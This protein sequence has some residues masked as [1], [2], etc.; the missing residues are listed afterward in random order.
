MKGTGTSKA[1][2]SSP[3]IAHIR[4]VME[5]RNLNYRDAMIIGKETYTKVKRGPHRSKEELARMGGVSE[6]KTSPEKPELEMFNLG[7]KALHL[8]DKR[9]QFRSNQD[10][11]NY[12]KKE[13]GW[14]CDKAMTEYSRCHAKGIEITN[15][16]TGN[17]VT[18]A[19]IAN[20]GS[21]SVVG[22]SLPSS[23]KSKKSSLSSVGTSLPSSSSKS[24]K[25]SSSFGSIN[26][27][28]SKSSVSSF[29]SINSR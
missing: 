17:E 10:Y 1:T 24:S 26:S 28:S 11:L 25:S 2:L 6:T 5:D 27:K 4:K 15:L 7:W 18:L 29:G 12:A 9:E 16:I 22:T 3:W 13:F 21:R 20:P 8:N 19:T 23:S 14:D